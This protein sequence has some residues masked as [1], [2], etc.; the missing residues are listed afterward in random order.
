[1]ASVLAF[2]GRIPLANL[3]AFARSLHARQVTFTLS[4]RSGLAST[5]IPQLDGFNDYRPERSR[6][7]ALTAPLASESGRV[8]GYGRRLFSVRSREISRSIKLGV[9]AAV[10]DFSSPLVSN[11]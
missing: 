5:F 1:M 4:G 2:P 10:P 9:C 3:L 6:H 8:N 7:R 11:H